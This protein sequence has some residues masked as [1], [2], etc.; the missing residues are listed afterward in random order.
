MRR[1]L[2]LARESVQSMTGAEVG[3]LLVLSATAVWVTLRLPPLHPAQLWAI[4]WAAAGMLFALQLLP[5]RELSPLAAA[6]A[7]GATVA[8]VGGTVVGQRY[9]GRRVP[10]VANEDL[11][12]GLV[13]RAAIGALVLTA[14]SLIAF[15]W[16]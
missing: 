3:M 14:I 1:Q 12:Y 10:R 15:L 11:R 9:V 13:A 6:L 8:F 5:Y 7:A 16:Q 2:L 4:P